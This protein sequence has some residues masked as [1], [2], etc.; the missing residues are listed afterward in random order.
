MRRR[1]GGV[2]PEREEELGGDAC[3]QLV[4]R[5]NSPFTSRPVAAPHAGESTREAASGDRGSS[6]DESEEDIEASSCCTSKST[7]LFIAEFVRLIS[8]WSGR[9]ATRENGDAL[10][11]RTHLFGRGRD[12]GGVRVHG[13]DNFNFSKN[14]VGW[15]EVIV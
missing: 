2:G 8:G 15:E 9:G 1:V 6:A 12:D 5:L 3:A 11:E 7:S 4:R 14:K 13:R 10:P